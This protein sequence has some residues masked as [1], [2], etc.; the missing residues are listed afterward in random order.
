M[1]KEREEGE[2]RVSKIRQGE[3]VSHGYLLGPVR[4]PHYDGD[5]HKNLSGRFSQKKLRLPDNHFHLKECVACAGIPVVC[6]AEACRCF[7]SRLRAADPH[8]GKYEILQLF[9][10]SSACCLPS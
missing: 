5:T 10:F 2:S 7:A 3:L 1:K 8:P 4:L 6:L 9:C